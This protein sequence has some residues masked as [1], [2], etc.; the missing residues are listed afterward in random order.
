MT[1]TIHTWLNAACVLVIVGAAT[2]ASLLRYM[3]KDE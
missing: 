3:T 1:D 2:Y